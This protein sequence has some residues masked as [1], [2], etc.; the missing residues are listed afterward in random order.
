MLLRHYAKQ[1][2]LT[3]SDMKLGHLVGAFSVIVK[4]PEGSFP[5]QVS[6]EYNCSRSVCGGK[7]QMDGATLATL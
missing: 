4:L 6:V 2:L 3:H 1:V 7:G 5:A